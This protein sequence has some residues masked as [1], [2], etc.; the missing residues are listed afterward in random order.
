[1][2][3]EFEI[4]EYQQYSDEFNFK[5][6]EFNSLQDALN[7]VDLLRSKYDF[8]SRSEKTSNSFI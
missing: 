1:M 6:K 8:L 7:I 4:G 2:K 3:V 5:K